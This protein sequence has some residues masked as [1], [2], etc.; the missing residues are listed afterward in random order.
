MAVFDDGPAHMHDVK[1]FIETAYPV[2]REKNQAYELGNNLI[3]SYLAAKSEGDLLER[4]GVKLAVALELLK[5]RFLQQADCPVKE[6]ISSRSKFEKI[7]K[8]TLRPAVKQALEESKLDAGE[9]DAICEKLPELNR[10]GFS[11]V[12][13]AL[14]NMIGFQPTEE[15]LALFVKQRNAL[16]HAGHFYRYKP[17]DRKLIY[18]QH[19]DAENVVE[20][21]ESATNKASYFFMLN[22]LDRLFLKFFGYSGAYLNRKMHSMNNQNVGN[23]DTLAES[24]GGARPEPGTR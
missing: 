22:F 15:E 5:H 8:K 9:I 10:T 20:E 13:R 1:R 21:S 4:R 12:L 2:H 19:D 6:H 7:T 14:F 3:E 23:Y 11:K 24:D 18:I 17:E 16:V